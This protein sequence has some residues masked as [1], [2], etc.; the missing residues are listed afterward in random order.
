MTEAQHAF[1]AL[2]VVGV[3]RLTPDAAAIDLGVPDGLRTLFG[4]RPGQHVNVRATLGGAEVRR[5]YS[6]CTGPDAPHLRIAVKRVAGGAFSVWANDVLRPGMPL[7]VMPPQGR[8]ALAAADGTPRHILALAA[9]SGITPVLA[10]ALH[11][12]AR[13][14][15]TRVTLV[16]GNRTAADR[17]PSQSRR[18][19]R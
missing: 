4:F 8:F 16:Y 7:D 15:E 11:A 17:S 18:R 10:M 2:T 6:I 1:H 9:G 14:P 5:S 12:M 13:E 3:E 19:H